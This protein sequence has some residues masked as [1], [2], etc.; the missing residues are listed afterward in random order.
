MKK[1]ILF[2]LFIPIVNGAH[3]QSVEAVVGIQNHLISGTFLN[4]TGEID[5]FKN[6]SLMMHE[7]IGYRY[8]VIKFSDD[9]SLGLQAYIH[10]SQ[11]ITAGGNPASPSQ[12][13]DIQIPGYISFNYGA[14]STKNSYKLL[15]LGIGFGYSYHLLL[16]D[17]VPENIDDEGIYNYGNPSLMIEIP[18]YFNNSSDF[19]DTFKLR[20]EKQINLSD[21]EFR[22]EHGNYSYQF[23]SYYFSYVLYFN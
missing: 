3:S 15:G 16:C 4:Y 14:G 11:A 17:I 8:P 6:Q 9:V 13:F 1:L 21:I 5:E 19:F 18:F 20:F 22:S 2:C 10:I 7:A 23:D 12:R